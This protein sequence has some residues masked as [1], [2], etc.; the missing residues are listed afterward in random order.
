MHV[1]MALE[2]QLPAPLQ[3]AAVVR[4]SATHEAAAPQPVDAPAKTQ[5]LRFWVV[6]SQYP[7]QAPLPPQLVR[8]AV[9]GKHVPRLPATLH[10]SHCPSHEVSQQ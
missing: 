3:V 2:V 10:D 4:V 1:I 7:A 6:P 8:G 9:T 5:A